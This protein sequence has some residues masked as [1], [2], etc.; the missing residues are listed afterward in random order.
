MTFAFETK[1]GTF[2]ATRRAGTGP[3]SIP[4]RRGLDD[5]DADPDSK[6][7][8]I[9]A[10]GSI[11]FMRV[12]GPAD[13]AC[14][15]AVAEIRAMRKFPLQLLAVRQGVLTASD[16]SGRSVTLEADDLTL[17]DT[18][19]DIALRSLQRVDAW[20]IGLSEPMIAR[21]LQGTPA[22][23][24]HRLPGDR[25]WARVLSAYLRTWEFEPLHRLTS[26]FEKEIIGEHVMSLLSMTL[27]Q[28]GAA[29]DTQATRRRDHGLY[30]RMRQWIREN[31]E[32]PEINV[33]TLAAAFSVSTRYVHKVF[34]NAGRGETFLELLRNERLEAAARLLR[35]ATKT[36]TYVSEVAYRCGFSEPGYFGQV[37]RRK[38]GC[39]PSEFSKQCD[40]ASGDGTARP[41]LD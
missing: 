17:L 41:T 12:Q 19:G 7:C 24:A 36:R 9:V 28:S 39:P 37:F 15:Q 32:N 23:T 1:A 5:D 31:Y 38:Y 29:C 6:P 3:A 22:A 2:S 30:A 40:A 20:I 26:P 25:G 34:L 13:E 10:L 16:A 14:R 27:S 35:T 33:A 11:A 18:G 21:W 4:A 8:A